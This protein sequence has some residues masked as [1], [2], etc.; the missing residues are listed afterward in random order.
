MAD[1]IL[2]MHLIAGE[3]AQSYKNCDKILV[4]DK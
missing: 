4:G 1:N 3:R 2:R